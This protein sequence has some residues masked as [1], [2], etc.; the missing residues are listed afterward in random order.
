MKKKVFKKYSKSSGF[1]NEIKTDF[2]SQNQTLL[3]NALK[4]NQ[5]YS[6]QEKRFNC[7]LCDSELPESEDFKKHNVQYVFCRSCDHLNG[8]HKDTKEFANTIYTDD[9][10]SKYSNF[11]L[12][13]KYEIRIE[14][15]YMP[16]IDFIVPYLEN[17]VSIFDFGCGLGHFVDCAL[18]KG[19]KARGADVSK[20]LVENGNLAIRHN[21]NIEPLDVVHPE[22][23]KLLLEPMKVDVL[24]ALAVIEHLVD[25]NAFIN[26][27]KKCDFKYFYYSVPTYGLSVSI[28]SVF[29]DVF[30]RHL[31]SGHTHLF[32]E[33]SL[34]L[35]NK[36]LG[37][38]P[39]AQWRFGT[40]VMDLRRSMDV[41]L[42]KV[43]ASDYFRDRVFK[44]TEKYAD[45]LQSVIDK[46]HN[47]SQIHVLAKKIK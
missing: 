8:L 22:N 10:G 19:F 41:A 29:Q 6:K 12:D 44:E 30:P 47:C 2:F 36:K 13:D 38:K 34:E 16:K 26:S 43:E 14:N 4:I 11:Y 1:Y 45:E 23:V 28:E 3:S 24:S 31:S 27:V 32:T 37:I 21:H 15:I 33:T 35:L 46:A 39:I 20:T 42:K 9:D 17:G 7:K 18:R 5:L 25:L 40:D